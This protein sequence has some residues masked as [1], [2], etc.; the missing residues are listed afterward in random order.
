MWCVA[1][2]SLKALLVVL[3]GKILVCFRLVERQARTPA[4]R[5]PRRYHAR[6]GR[7]FRLVIDFCR[8]SC[9]DE[10][11]SRVRARLASPRVGWSAILVDK[12]RLTWRRAE[13]GLP[14]ARE[15]NAHFRCSSPSAVSTGTSRTGRRAMGASVPRPQCTAPPSSSISP[16]R[17]VS[18]GGRLARGGGP[19]GARS[20][21]TFKRLGAPAGSQGRGL[22][23]GEASIRERDRGERNP[24]R[25]P[26]DFFILKCGRQSPGESIVPRGGESPSR[27]GA[28]SRPR[29]FRGEVE[30]VGPGAKCSAWLCGFREGLGRVSRRQAAQGSW[31]LYCRSW[32]KFVCETLCSVRD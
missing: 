29:A 13:L 14:T 9:A 24:R 21:G 18:E 5:K 30:H 26:N 22:R 11:E 12:W 6:L 19:G 7:D 32:C 10:S 15:S 1:W 25:T 16:P 2:R 20:R 8:R 17:L 31:G 27:G 28:T 4:K 3:T 23:K